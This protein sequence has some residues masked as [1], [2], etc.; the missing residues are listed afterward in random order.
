LGAAWIEVGDDPIQRRQEMIDGWRQITDPVLHVVSGGLADAG[1]VGAITDATGINSVYEQVQGA[2]E[3]RI[4]ETVY[5][6]LIPPIEDVESLNQWHDGL[7]QSV[8]AGLWNALYANPDIRASLCGVDPSQAASISVDELL[9][10]DR[11]QDIVDSLR[12]EIINRAIGQA[13]FAEVLGGREAVPYE[14]PE[15]E[16]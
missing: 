13:T 7:R 2:I 1:P 16:D 14:W 11:A 4:S 15:D 6:R 8:D 10:N 3:T 12:P 5:D 9:E